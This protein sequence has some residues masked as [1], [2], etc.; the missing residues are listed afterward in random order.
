VLPW[1]VVDRN[2]NRDC[3][4]LGPAE[5]PAIEEAR[6]LARSGQAALDA[7]MHR[8]RMMEMIPR[9]EWEPRWAEMKPG[10]VLRQGEGCAVCTPAG[11][12][13][14][15]DRAGLQRLAQ[16]V[17]A[18]YVWLGVTVVPLTR[19][20]K[21]NRPDDCCREVLAQ[22]GKAVLA[23]SSV[24][25]VRAT[26]GT[27]VWERDARRLEREVPSRAGRVARTPAKR[28]WYAVRTT[29]HLLANAFG[30]EHRKSLK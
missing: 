22:E 5:A 23:R 18:D 25:L 1:L 20:A 28:R 9:K 3:E 10:S 27:L 12:L 21:G 16:A 15:Y 24:L 19:E 30:R 6:R 2:T 14:R 4:K 17:R 8:H 7:A 11:Q 29:A 26:D 13:I